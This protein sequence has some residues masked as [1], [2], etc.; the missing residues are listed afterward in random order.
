MKK[1]IFLSVMYFVPSLSSAFN[2]YPDINPLLPQYIIGFG[3][4]IDE[5]SKK[6]TVPLAEESLPVLISGYKRSWSSHENL[7]GLNATFLSVQEDGS[8]SF[9]GVVCKRYRSLD[10]G[11]AVIQD[12]GL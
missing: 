2:C 1:L 9:N 4:L 5:Q 10:V 6:R 3:S 8:S 12:I 7:P 11:A